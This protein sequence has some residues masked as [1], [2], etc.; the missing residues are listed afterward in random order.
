[1][2]QADEKERAAAQAAEKRPP[3]ARTLSRKRETSLGL[4]LPERLMDA[5]AVDT[6]DYQ[7]YGWNRPPAACEIRYRRAPLSPL[8]R[9]A[10]NGRS[11]TRTHHGSTV[12]RYLLA[13]RPQPRIED[14]V[15]IGELMRLAALARFGWEMDPQTGR[16]VAQAPPEISGREATG[17]PLRDPGHAH[18]FWLPEDADGDGKIDHVCVYAAAAFDTRVRSALDRL[19]RLWVRTGA[20]TAGNGNEEGGRREWRLALEGFGSCAEFSGVSAL[21]GSARVWQSVTPFLPTAHLKRN[22]DGRHARHLLERGE[23]VAGTLAEATG[24]PREVRR[25]LQRRGMLK[26]SLAEH[27]QVAIL[28]HVIVH[29]APR[30][31]LQFHRFRSRGREKA[32]DAHGALLQLR[33]PEPIAGPVA[34]GYGCH[35][36]LGLFCA[37]ETKE[38]ST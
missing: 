11:M 32:T 27:L 19:T 34:L 37:S 16:R 24:Y 8:A 12:A 30:R 21:F 18:A 6:A 3:T 26:E 36:G 25:L 28:P 23:I 2:A 10:I 29:G 31:A 17:G 14:A 38:T 5:L 22:G 4:T 20:A 1:M 33:F 35:F 15:R 9:R 7:K 13:G